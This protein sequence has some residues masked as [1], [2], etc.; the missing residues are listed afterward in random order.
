MADL[1]LKALPTICVIGFLIYLLVEY[2]DVVRTK[3]ALMDISG[4]KLFGVELKFAERSL[5]QLHKPSAQVTAKLNKSEAKNLL[6]NDEEKDQILRRAVAVYPLL[7][8]SRILWVDDRP[9]NNILQRNFLQSLGISVD[10]AQDNKTAYEL[11]QLQELN[12]TPYDLVI[13]DYSRD[14]EPEESG[15]KLLENMREGHFK[16]QIIYF[17]GKDRT[18]PKNAFQ[19]TTSSGDLLNFVFDVLERSQKR[20]KT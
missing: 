14:N 20:R 17:V 11:L 19:L 13:S 6:L 12:E 15:F 1:V 7:Q 3:L 8:D 9:S 18:K 16:Q 4:L 2:G 5:Q 10:C